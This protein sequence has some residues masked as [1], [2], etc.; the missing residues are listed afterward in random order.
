MISSTF[1]SGN[2]ND[3]DKMV[4]EV[5]PQSLFTIEQIIIPQIDD[6]LLSMLGNN[7]NIEKE[8]VDITQNCSNGV[9]EGLT[10]D[11]L[12]LV[13]DFNVPE[14]PQKAIDADTEAIRNMF[15]DVGKYTLNNITIDVN[16]GNLLLQFYIPL[17]P[18][19]VDIQYS[20]EE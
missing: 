10:L 9:L 18:S 1:K 8:R 13:K 16:Q 4:N 11:L 19:T 7:T 12:Y 15:V 20:E 17:D 2:Y 6:T 3:W 5:F 14:A